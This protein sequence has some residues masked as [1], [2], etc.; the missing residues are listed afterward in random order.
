MP[1]S[2]APDDRLV[3][4]GH[5]AVAVNVP[6]PP[7]QIEAPV[8]ETAT[9]SAIVV[10]GSPWQPLSEVVTVYVPAIATVALVLT[11]GFCADEVKL[12]GPVQAYVAPA[13]VEAVNERLDP[14]HT[15]P[16]SLTVG[17]AGLAIMV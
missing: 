9:T 13:T 12:L 3:M 11:V 2:F 14:K 16:L 6:L 5:E 4:S 15:G 17:V 7:T 1:A 8:V 10:P